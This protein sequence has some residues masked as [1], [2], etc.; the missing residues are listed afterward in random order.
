M[1]NQEDERTKYGGQAVVEGVMMRSPRYFAV[2]CR[3]ET[4]Q[5]IV[6]QVDNVE[7]HMARWKW[8]NKPF[9]RGTLALID[10]FGMG[11]K[12]LAYSAGVQ[13]QAEEEAARARGEAPDAR[14]LNSEERQLKADAGK[15][16][17]SI[18]IGGATT[19]AL[20][21]ALAFIYGVPTLATQGI[22]KAERWT[23]PNWH[24]GL[25]L[26][27]VDLAIRL[28]FFLGYIGL[29]S[30]MERIQRVFQYHGAEHK[31]INTLERGAPLTVENARESSRIHPRCGTNF[32]FIVF[33]TH[34][35]VVACFGRPEPALRVLINL[36]VLPIV[37]GIAYEILRFAG[38]RRDKKWAQTLIAPGLALQ[39]LTTRVP[40]DSQL[41]VALAS[42]LAVW[43]K[44][45]ARPETAYER[46]IEEPADAVA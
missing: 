43:N 5:Q 3:R 34:F 13:L 39:Y 2:A 28:G 22:Q 40:D 21:I 32:V 27:A 1:P 11:Y 42:L 10:S 19:V 23:H 44:E 35:F 9:L 41:E 16:I 30:R 8:L 20:L 15:P 6:V 45:H 26:N 24:Q 38:T 17:N 7:Q 18:A 29:I 14:K 25:L 37:A 4:D 36:A 46:T 33:L 12:A 31:A